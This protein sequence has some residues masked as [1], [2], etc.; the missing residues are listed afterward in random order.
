MKTTGHQVLV[1]GGGRGIGLALAKRFYEAKNQLVLVGRDARALDEAAQA[2]PGTKVCVADISSS[3][4][5]ERVVNTFTDVSVLINNAGIQRMGEFEQMSA[6]EIEQE[7]QVNLIAPIL[8][9]RAFLPILKT[10]DEAAIVN[11]SSMLALM[12]KQ[13]ASVYC[14]SKAGLHSFTQ[15]LRWQLETTGV[16]VF[17]IAPLLVDTA[18]A[19]GRGGKRKISADALANEFWSSFQSNRFGVYVGKAKVVKVLIRL[20]PSVA[21]RLIRRG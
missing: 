4:D 5:R 3:E 11:V 14:A 15:S 2:M 10:H 20:F 17:E 13:S 6:A 16:R 19:A 18:M 1:T 9:T 7:L 8:L 12:P 21:E